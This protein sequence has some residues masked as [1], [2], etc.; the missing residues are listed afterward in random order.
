MLAKKKRQAI[1]RRELTGLR[2]RLWRF[3]LARTGGNRAD[4]DDLFQAT[5]L[6]AL[7]KCQQF[8]PGTRFDNWAYTIAV[9]IWRNELRSRSVRTGSGLVDAGEANLTAPENTGEMNIFASEVLNR[10]MALPQAQRG[11]VQLVYMD[12]YSYREAAEILSIPI[13]TVMSR[14]A[15]ARKTLKAWAEHDVQ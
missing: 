13:G 4:A 9:S 1:V 7:E 12:G 10:I 8:E 15:T 11:V 14:L 3:C 6:R 5:A 2:E